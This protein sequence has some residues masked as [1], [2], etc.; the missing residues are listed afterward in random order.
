MW[1]WFLDREDPLE[2]EMATHSSILAWKVP[3]T[4]ESVRLQSTEL[5]RVR[6]NWSSLAQQVC[7]GSTF[8]T[9][10]TVNAKTLKM[11]PDRCIQKTAMS[12]EGCSNSRAGSMGS[13][14][15]S[16]GE[17]GRGTELRGPFFSLVCNMNNLKWN[18][19]TQLCPTLCNP[20]TVAYQAPPS[21]GCHSLKISLNL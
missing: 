5:K 12:K 21:M 13:M 11:K 16:N 1:V 10:G 20:W 9:E 2:K 17:C 14:A 6:H 19:V 15:R 7:G 8:Q 4:E 3:W 18:E